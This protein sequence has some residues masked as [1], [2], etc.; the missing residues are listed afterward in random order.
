M[1]N[2]KQWVKL[3]PWAEYW[4]NSFFHYIIGI[5]PFKA[6]YQRDPPILVKYKHYPK[7]Q[8]IVQESM[9]KRCYSIGIED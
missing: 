4:Y 3:L 9:S 2:L 8:K 5:T 1:Q 7:V 6:L